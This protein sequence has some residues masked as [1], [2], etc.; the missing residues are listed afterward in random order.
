MI[1]RNTPLTSTAVLAA[2]GPAWQPFFHHA[3]QV[4]SKAA[5]EICHCLLDPLLLQNDGG[6]ILPSE[7]D[8]N[9]LLVVGEWSHRW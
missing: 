1:K 3:S 4:K 2:A 9:V 8:S 7:R 5:A 6:Y